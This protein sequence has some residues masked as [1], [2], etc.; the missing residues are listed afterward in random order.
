M[1]SKVPLRDVVDLKP[2]GCRML[3]RGNIIRS[4]NKYYGRMKFE[5]AWRILKGKHHQEL[6]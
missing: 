6:Q 5:D 4:C 3:K 1:W 2:Q